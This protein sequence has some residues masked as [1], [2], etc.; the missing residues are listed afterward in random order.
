MARFRE[1]QPAHHS[2]KV[3]VE[4]A[5]RAFMKV[6][7]KRRRELLESGAS[8]DG[9]DWLDEDDLSAEHTTGENRPP[10]ASDG[11]QA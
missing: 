4:E 3:S 8:G 7:A 6:R 10:T 5:A 2:D 9:H 11:N 1:L